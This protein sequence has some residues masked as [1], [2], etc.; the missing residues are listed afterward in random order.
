MPPLTSL[1]LHAAPGK[2]N[3]DAHGGTSNPPTFFSNS[4]NR[5]HAVNVLHIL[6]RTLNHVC[7]T[8]EPRLTN[9][10]GIELL[11]EP[12]G[13]DAG[14]AAVIGGYWT[15]AYRAVR[16]AAGPE[17]QV[18]IGDA[19]LGVAVRSP[20]AGFPDLVNVQAFIGGLRQNWDGFMTSSNQDQGVLMDYV[21]NL[22]G[23]GEPVHM[24]D[25]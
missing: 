19:F 4:R 22:R 10:V 13:F 17:L 11:N 1:D 6:L 3:N 18:M 14:V 9:V 15:D 25:V 7:R 5:D 12:A 21:S 24:F 23:C 8:H 2:Q 16:E 20:T